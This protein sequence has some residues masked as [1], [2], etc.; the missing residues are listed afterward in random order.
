L[1]TVIIDEEVIKKAKIKAIEDDTN[2]SRVADE[3][4]RGW[5]SGDYKLKQ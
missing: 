4:L 1:L 5:L 2:V 3:L